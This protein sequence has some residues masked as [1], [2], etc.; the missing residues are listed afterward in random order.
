M[1]HKLE[2]L[3]NLIATNI[4]VSLHFNIWLGI[5]NIVGKVIF[6]GN[7]KKIGKFITKRIYIY[8]QKKMTRDYSYL[9]SEYKRKQKKDISTG[10]LSK[11]A[12]IWIF[13]WQGLN[14]APCVVK[15]CIQSISHRCGGHPIILITSKNYKEYV[16][17]PAYIIKKISEKKI[18]LTHF[19]DVLRLALL[20]EHGGIWMDA[21]LWM[22]NEFPLEMDNLPLYTLKHGQFADYHVSRGLWSS[23]FISAGKNN[24]F[25]TFSRD[26]L[27]EYWKKEDYSIG[28]L[29]IDVAF[30]IAIDNFEWAKNMISVIPQNNTSVFELQEHMNEVFDESQFNLWCESTFVH[31][32]SYKIPFKLESHGSKT[33]W[34]FFYNNKDSV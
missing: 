24:P 5:A 17:I 29:L 2:V 18:T 34:G 28:Y 26:F 6:G 1:K 19:S 14:N 8:I 23:F 31:K 3:K 13:W 25:I 16:D 20:S 32:V 4:Q 33:Y 27:Y 21:T 15:N 12:P 30:C 9:I 7:R 22:T 10:H 11:N